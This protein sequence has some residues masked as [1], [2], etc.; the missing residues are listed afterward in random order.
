MQ[1]GFYGSGWT[2][3]SS[4]CAMAIIAVVKNQLKRG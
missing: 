1:F 2:V 4:A 3:P